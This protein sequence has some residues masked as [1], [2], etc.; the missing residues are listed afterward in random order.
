MLLGGSNRYN[1]SESGDRG[2]R[3]R[4]GGVGRGGAGTSSASRGLG[5]VE[6]VLGREGKLGNGEL[7]D[8]GGRCGKK[9]F[10]VKRYDKR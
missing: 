7:V 10:I 9:S 2:G 1:S 5:R 4:G 3:G 6:L 8:L